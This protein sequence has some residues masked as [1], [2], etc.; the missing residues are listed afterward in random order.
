[1]RFHFFICVIL[2]SIMSLSSQARMIEKENNFV[3]KS[4]ELSVELEVDGG[5]VHVQPSQDKRD[6]F[7]SMIYPRDKCDIDIR[8]NEG[9]P[10]Y[11]RF[12]NAEVPVPED[13]EVIVQGEVDDG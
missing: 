6:C 11:F 1:M 2:V 8:F 9:Q 7:I 4:K 10:L 12:I 5:T 3:I 13:H